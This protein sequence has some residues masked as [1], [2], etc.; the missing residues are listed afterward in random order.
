MVFNFTLNFVKLLLELKPLLCMVFYLFFQELCILVLSQE[1]NLELLISLHQ[2]LV[3]F[4]NFLRHRRHGFKSLSGRF[5]L[6]S[7]LVLSFALV[8]SFKQFLSEL[9]EL[10]VQSGPLPVLLLLELQLSLLLHQADL[11][12]DLRLVLSDLLHSLGVLVNSR[13]GTCVVLVQVFVDL[14]LETSVELKLI[15]LRLWSNP[16]RLFRYFI[17]L[18]FQFVYRISVVLLAFDVIPL[19][20]QEILS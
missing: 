4:V 13:L 17:D 11:L 18:F 12:D 7:S 8:F 5:V 3:V 2:L 20:L 1:L 16:Q 15:V 19:L 6:S 10:L 9:L 14:K